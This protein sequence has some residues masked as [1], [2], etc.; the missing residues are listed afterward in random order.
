MLLKMRAAT[1]PT[2]I[3]WSIV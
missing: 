3:S 1:P 2:E